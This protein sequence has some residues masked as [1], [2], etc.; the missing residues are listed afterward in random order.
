[1]LWKL[2]I[3]SAAITHWLSHRFTCGVSSVITTNKFASHTITSFM[4]AGCL[5]CADSYVRVSYNLSSR[6]NYRCYRRNVSTWTHL[7]YMFLFTSVLVICSVILMLRTYAFSGKK[8]QILAILLI[9]FFGLFGVIV[10]VIS[11]EL[12]R[13]SRKQYSSRRISDIMKSQC[14]PCSLRSIAAHVSPF[15]MNQLSVKY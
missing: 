5:R 11:K 15:R 1:M 10:W 14:H 6:F 3:Y 9:T 4:P 12:T 2:H 7:Q 8:I 13:L